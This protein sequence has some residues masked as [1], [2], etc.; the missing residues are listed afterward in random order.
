[1]P[2]KLAFFWEQESTASVPTEMTVTIYQKTYRPDSLAGHKAWLSL[3]PRAELTV[4][5]EDRRGK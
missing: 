1:M 4:P 3:E 5:I 2:E